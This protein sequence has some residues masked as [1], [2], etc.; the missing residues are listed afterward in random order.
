[1]EEKLDLQRN[2]RNLKENLEKL[3]KI[4]LNIDFSHPYLQKLAKIHHEGLQIV[5]NTN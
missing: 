2:S 5:P 4:K 3:G 1:M